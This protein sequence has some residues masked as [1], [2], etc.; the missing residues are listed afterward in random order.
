MA[1]RVLAVV[2][3]IIL[4][5]V[6]AG[7]AVAGGALMVLFGS[8]N[9]IS[10]GGAP[11]STQTTALVA[12]MDDIKDTKGFAAAVGQP[13]LR[14]SLTSTGGDVFIGVGPAAAVDQYFAGASIDRV[15]DLEVDPFK[16]KTVPRDGSATPAAPGVQT[17][18]TVRASGSTAALNWK[19]SDG[20][21]RL[22]VM[23]A[24]A[25][26][27]VNAS[28]SVGLNVPNLFAIGIGTLIGGVVIALIGLALLIIGVR[29]RPNPPPAMPMAAAYPATPGY[30]SVA[31]RGDNVPQ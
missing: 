23:N 4:F 15:T 11:L 17:F 21:Y 14:L 2:F 26:T 10:S 13:T 7:A 20:S 18:W 9:T 6:G 24:D 28:G 12:P 25:S 29:M 8:D 1:K 31:P 3:G 30:P 27:G 16:L 5:L 22:V 19:I